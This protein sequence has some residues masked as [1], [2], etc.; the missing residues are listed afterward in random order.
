M[1]HKKILLMIDVTQLESALGM[2]LA[3]LLSSVP[4]LAQAAAGAVEAA[5]GADRPAFKLR[6]RAQHVFSEAGR[7]LRF[8]AVCEASTG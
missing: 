1:T 7:V 4:R 8:R 5:G 6:Q 2:P 3:H